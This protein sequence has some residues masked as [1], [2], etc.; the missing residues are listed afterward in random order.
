MSEIPNED[1][2]EYFPEY[3]DISKPF[4]YTAFCERIRAGEASAKDHEEFTIRAMQM[5][6]R[7]IY[8]DEEPEKWVQYYFADQFLKILHGSLWCDEL[9][10]PWVPQ[11]QIRTRAEEQGLKI[12]CDVENAKRASPE[13]KI[14]NLL[15]E[16]AKKYS[17]SYETAR[18]GYY[19]GKHLHKLQFS[20]SA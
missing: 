15:N 1:D 18:A 7:A 2:S 10:L 19:K 3:G 6:C 12:F 13:K 8:C 20:D 14:T 4:D 9:P 11:S 16:A 17:V 5:F